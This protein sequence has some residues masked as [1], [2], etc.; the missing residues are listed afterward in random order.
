MT[1]NQKRGTQKRETNEK[2]AQVAQVQ[3]PARFRPTTWTAIA[4]LDRLRLVG[5]CLDEQFRGCYRVC[6]SVRHFRGC[7][8]RYDVVIQP[9]CRSTVL[10]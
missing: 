4:R 5:S 8:G 9:T 2:R 3:C 6:N 1:Q 10:S 7:D